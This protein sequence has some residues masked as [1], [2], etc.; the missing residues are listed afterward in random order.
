MISE[1]RKREIVSAFQQQFKRDNADEIAKIT[2]QELLDTDAMLADRD[3]NAGFRIKVREC[4]A[5]L[6]QNERRR[7]ESRVRAGN[8]VMGIVTGLIIAGLAAWLFR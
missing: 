2:L 1:D 5:E 4:I 3:I 8:Y 7:H 6:Q